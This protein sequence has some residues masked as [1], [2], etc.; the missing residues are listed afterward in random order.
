M[1]NAVPVKD[2]LLLLGTDAVVLVEKVEELALGLF[3]RGISAGLEIS[4]IG[5]NALLELFGVFYRTAK[6]LESERQTSDDV[7][8]G[9]VEESVPKNAGDVFAC[10]EEETTNVLILLPVNRSRD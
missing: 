7:S 4:Q 1:R 9:D 6:G 5:E 10:G 2:L 3:Q 8:A